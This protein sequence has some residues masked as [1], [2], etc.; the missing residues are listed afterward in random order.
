MTDSTDP[1]ALVDELR[2]D[3][4]YGEERM[5]KFNQHNPLHM[6]AA[7]ALTAALDRAEKAEAEA[8]DYFMTW[9]DKAD[10]VEARGHMAGLQ[11]AAD[12]YYQGAIIG[13][14][15][16]W[17]FFISAYRAILARIPADSRK[18]AT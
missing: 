7:D 6:H 13:G 2:K 15:G 10:E 17:D 18:D 16:S 1:R 11:E 4:F 9:E 5:H 14:E 3:V 8:L 12:A